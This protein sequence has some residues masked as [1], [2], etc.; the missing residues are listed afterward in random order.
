[1]KDV[2]LE[3]RGLHAR[4]IDWTIVDLKGF[5]GKFCRFTYPELA[6]F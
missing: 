6:F 1:M 4:S 3:T 5:M 2:S